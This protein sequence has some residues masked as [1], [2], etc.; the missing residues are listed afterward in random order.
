[1]ASDIRGILVWESF[2]NLFFNLKRPLFYITFCFA[3]FC[4]LYIFYI[5]KTIT[6][7][8]TL[9]RS[10]G[11]KIIFIFVIF[12]IFV[13]C[14]STSN[15]FFGKLRSPYIRFFIMVFWFSILTVFI[16]CVV[17]RFDV[18]DTQKVTSFRRILPFKESPYYR[19]DPILEFTDIAAIEERGTGTINGKGFKLKNG[20]YRGFDFEHIP[21]LSVARFVYN[22]YDNCDWLKGNIEDQFFW[23][24]KKRNVYEAEDTNTTNSLQDTI[25]FLPVIWLITME[26]LFVIIYTLKRT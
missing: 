13:T 9:E 25:I 7:Q 11:Y 20:K 10:I 14:Y 19:I 21:L 16:S 2:S 15:V 4:F 5:R 22:L 12:T 24:I 23:I 17:W 6:V 3:V 18:Y 26:F 1:M 8:G